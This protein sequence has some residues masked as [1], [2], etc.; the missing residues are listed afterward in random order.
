MVNATA[1]LLSVHSTASLHIPQTL[2]PDS[3][4]VVFHIKPGVTLGCGF[5]AGTCVLL[6]F[7]TRNPCLKGDGRLPQ[8]AAPA[9]DLITRHHKGS[10]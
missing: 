10:K 7:H 6:Y 1:W 2:K 5:K 3:C 8:M 9:R 4:H